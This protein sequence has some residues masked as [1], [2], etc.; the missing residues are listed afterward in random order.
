[1]FLWF[2]NENSVKGKHEGLI[3]FLSLA[4]PSKASG[5]ALFIS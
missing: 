1:M 4:T 5:S 2:K 3:L